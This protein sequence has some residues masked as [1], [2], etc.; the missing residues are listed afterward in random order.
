M[1]LRARPL[2][3]LNVAPTTEAKPP[4]LPPP[5]NPPLV[6]SIEQ[7]VPKRTLALVRT[8]LRRLRR[9]LRAAAAG[10][11]SLARRLRPADL[12]LP[13]ADHSVE[14][15]RPWRW[16]LSPLA[17]GEPAVPLPVSG[18]EGNTPLTDLI[19]SEFGSATNS[20]FTD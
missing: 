5:P 6:T 20:T 1:R 4:P 13:H 2:P 15:T 10:N 12:W 14:A 3:R 9:S 17:R 18:R 8:W 16:N 11:H 19:L 7:V